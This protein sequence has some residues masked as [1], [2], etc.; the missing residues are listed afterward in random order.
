MAFPMWEPDLPPGHF[1]RDRVLHQERV[2]DANDWVVDEARREGDCLKIDPSRKTIFRGHIRETDLSRFN[3]LLL[4]AANLC[5][6]PLLVG[7][8]LVHGPG[9]DLPTIS[10]S[11]GREEL[12]PGERKEMKFPREAFGSY[13]FPAG[14][15]D[16]REVEVTVGIERHHPAPRSIE[17]SIG[18]LEAQFRE[19]PEGPRMSRE[20]LRTVL[21]ADVRGATSFFRPRLGKAKNSGT[22]AEKD[23]SWAPYL[24]GDPG[25]FVPAPYPYPKDDPERILRGRVMGQ[26]IGY[27]IDW[28]ANP[29]GALEWCHF[30]HRQHFLRGLVLGLVNT[31]DARYVRALD[32]IISSWIGS[33][34]VPAGSNGGAG[35]SWETLSAAWRFREW[36]W[37]IGIAWP[38]ESFRRETKIDMLCSI[39]EHARSL[40]D[41]TGHPNNWIIV[42]SAALA[43]AGLYFPEFTEADR[44]VQ[45]GFERLRNEFGR[46]FFPDGAHFEISPLYHSICVHALLEVKRAAVIKGIDAPPEF[47][48][49]LEKCFEYLMH[50]CRPDFTWPSLNDSGGVAGNYTGLMLLASDVFHR[51]DFRWIGSRGAT[52]TPPAKASVF[53]QDAGIASMRSGYSEE[54]NFLVFRAGPPGA[55]HEH[56]DSLSLDVTGLGFPRL[57]D[58]GITSYAPGPMTDYY[59]SYAAHNVIL[60]DGHGPDRSGMAFHNTIRPP[61]EDFHWLCQD[62]L[63]VATGICRGPWRHTTSGE[64]FLGRTVAFVRRE[65]WVIRD[66]ITGDGSHEITACWQFFPGLVDVDIKTHAA[67]CVDARGPG[68]Q[69]VPLA[70]RQDVHMEILTGSL[71]PPRGWVSMNGTDLQATACRYSVRAVLPM[72]MIWVL[73]PF[74]GRSQSGITVQRTDG[75]RGDIVVEIALQD[76]SRDILTFPYPL[77]V[78]A[79]ITAKGMQEGV[80]LS[81]GVRADQ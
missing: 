53:F 46:Q 47:D 40:M 78:G 80:N 63:E 58:P 25:L 37:V 24:P 27:P 33:N 65:Y 76:G 77:A 41:H 38:F 39:W 50:L 67:V 52:G 17:A 62:D 79:E 59:R 23:T 44:W 9:R 7:V 1:A 42:E 3:S 21:A 18:S 49:P 72:T 6:S 55:F 75:E 71:C 81:G 57:V 31:G 19:I 4:V 69:L 43:L 60:I 8:K 35:P 28:D 12:K 54:A 48:S 51:P 11:G 74:S 16:V 13:G 73:V 14:W 61:G 68:F 26:R 20:G 36:L 56:G 70:G 66:V 2:I 45:T 30:L 64:S 22:G 29:L 32:R 15:S 5:E 34:T 10:L